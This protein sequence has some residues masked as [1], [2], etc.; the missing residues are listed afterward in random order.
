MGAMRARRR[1]EAPGSGG[2]GLGWNGRGDLGE[3]A[4][5]RR[6]RA[7]AVA[8]PLESPDLGEA[9]EILGACF[10]FSKPAAVIEPAS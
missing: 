6:L 5:G 7:R 4:E 3:E 1:G 9:A 8:S 10:L 2:T